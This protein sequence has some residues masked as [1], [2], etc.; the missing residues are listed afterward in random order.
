MRYLLPNNRSTF[1]STYKAGLSSKIY[2]PLN[3]GRSVGPDNQFGLF[4]TKPDTDSVNL[5]EWINTQ[6]SLGNINSGIYSGDGS[7]PVGGTTVSGDTL[8]INLT[9][10]I[11][12]KV[13]T[14]A[15][16]SVYLT[17]TG[18]QLT[19]GGESSGSPYVYNFPTTPFSEALNAY[20][21][22][23]WYMGLPQI[24]TFPGWSNDTTAASQGVLVGE[25]YYNT[26]I[27]KLVTR[28]T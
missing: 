22:M 24:Y 5:A 15:D 2:I 13:T 26:T 18:N 3:N 25:I 12:N 9:D 10:T 16:N 8:N 1:N 7:I 23:L 14:D 11:T 21:I 4:K 19:I 20:E 27:G 28:V 6:S 17:L